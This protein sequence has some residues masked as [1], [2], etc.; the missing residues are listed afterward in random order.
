MTLKADGQWPVYGYNLFLKALKKKKTSLEYRL[1]TWGENEAHDWDECKY[2]S[3]KSSWREFLTVDR[4][5]KPSCEGCCRPRASNLRVM[6]PQ[7]NQLNGSDVIETTCVTCPLYNPVCVVFSPQSLSS[8]LSHE[9][10]LRTWR[11][12]VTL[13]FSIYIY[14]LFKESMFYCCLLV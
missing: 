3:W 5:W 1:S 10:K 12:I 8:R 4:E 7:K 14:S 2:A 13:T 11:R 9:C 6:W